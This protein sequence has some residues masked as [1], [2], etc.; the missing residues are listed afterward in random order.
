M[1]LRV[2]CFPFTEPSI[3]RTVHKVGLE[4]D[5]EHQFDSMNTELATHV[6]SKWNK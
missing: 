4:N 3:L 1:T 2:Q 5:N 6:Q